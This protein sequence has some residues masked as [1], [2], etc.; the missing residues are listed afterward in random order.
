MQFSI[1]PELQQFV[2]AQIQG[3]AYP[4]AD[5]LLS[6]AIRLLAEHNLQKKKRIEAMDQ[7]IQVGLDE[8]ANGDY[9]DAEEVWKKLDNIIADD[10]QKNA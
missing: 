3:G 5:A 4:S 7:F 10:E 9:C 2:N 8:A 1:T 6:D